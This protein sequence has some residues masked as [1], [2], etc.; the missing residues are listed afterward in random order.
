MSFGII[1]E[2]PAD[3]L[4]FLMAVP[5]KSQ[6]RELFSSEYAVKSIFGLVIAGSQTA[7]VAPKFRLNFV[8]NDAESA[9]SEI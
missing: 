1:N 5:V 8:N 2:Y 3:D 7:A 6:N 9:S 4:F